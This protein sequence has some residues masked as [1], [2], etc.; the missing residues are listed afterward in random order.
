MMVFGGHING[1][2]TTEDGLPQS[3][4][5]KLGDLESGDE[6]RLIIHT[7][8]DPGRLAFVLDFLANES[9]L[10]KLRVEVPEPV[11]VPV[12][13]EHLESDR[14]DVTKRWPS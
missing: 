2:T 14:G 11:S 1:M 3:F 4:T 13:T 8:G 10:R 9:H 5:T 7:D 6:F 12:V